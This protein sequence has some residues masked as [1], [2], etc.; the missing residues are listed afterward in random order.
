MSERGPTMPL[1][2]IALLM[3]ALL[4]IVGAASYFIDRTAGNTGA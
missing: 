1:L 4:G 2:V 3:F